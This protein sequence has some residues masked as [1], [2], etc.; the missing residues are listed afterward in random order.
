ML[1]PSSRPAWLNRA[2][3][4]KTPTTDARESVRTRSVELDGREVLF[5]TVRMVGGKLKKYEGQEGLKEAFNIAM[6]KK[7]FISFN[8]PEE[9]TVF[10]KGLSKYISKLRKGQQLKRTT[11]TI[12]FGYELSEDKKEYIPVE[13]ELELLEKSF[14]YVTT[15]G[16]AKAARWLS[17]ASGRKISN[18]GLTK[19]MKLGLHLDR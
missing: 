9:A 15:C 16:A 18:P 8:T 3:N 1:S 2:L 19:R 6:K 13:K 7:D 12:P 4:P 11:S 14:N 17:T 10:S 5:P